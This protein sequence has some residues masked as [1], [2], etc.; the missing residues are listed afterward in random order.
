MNFDK[1][2][3]GV[4][5]R[6]RLMYNDNAL[7]VYERVTNPAELPTVQHVM[8]FRREKQGGDRIDSLRSLEMKGAL[9]AGAARM[10]VTVIAALPDRVIRRVAPPA[11]VIT[12]IF[13]GKQAIR[14][15]AGA[16]AEIESGLKRD[17]AKRMNP[18]ARLRDSREGSAAVRVA[19]QGRL[20][21]EDVWIVRVER[22]FE[23][24][25]T[26]YVSTTTGLLKKEEAWITASG[27][28]TVPISILFDDYREVAGVKIPFRS[29]SESALSGKQTFQVSEAKANPPIN[30]KTFAVPEG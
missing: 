8:A 14:Q 4:A 17:E 25:L 6:M 19:G 10:D 16:P 11:G 24:P 15:T 22:E 27:V 26:R 18:L 5:T 3:S 20:N 28:G 12:A 7:V 9:N 23:P 1:D 29:T 21:G 2:S 13:D 30:E